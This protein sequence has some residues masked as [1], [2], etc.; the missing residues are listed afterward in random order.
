[1][2]LIAGASLGTPSESGSTLTSCPTI[3]EE[4]AEIPPPPP[5]IAAEQRRAK[6]LSRLQSGRQQA[7]NRDGTGESL[8]LGR[9]QKYLTP[10]CTSKRNIL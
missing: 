4:E 9:S 1:M 7:G 8:A 2:C 5:P 3:P 6:T 10:Q